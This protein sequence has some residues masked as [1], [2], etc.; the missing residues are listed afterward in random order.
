MCVCGGCVVFF[1]VVCVGCVCVCGVWVCVCVF[2]GF[3][4]CVCV[5]FVLVLW[6]CVRGCECGV[7]VRVVCVVCFL[8]EMCVVW[9]ISKFILGSRDD[10]RRLS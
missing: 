6:L 9:F 5:W 1:V 3:V 2:G 7:V 4:V 10:F 8:G